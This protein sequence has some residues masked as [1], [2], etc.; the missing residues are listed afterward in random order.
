[1]FYVN[2]CTQQNLRAPLNGTKNGIKHNRAHRYGKIISDVVDYTSL[3]LIISLHH[4]A[5]LLTLYQQNGNNCSLIKEH[6]VRF[7]LI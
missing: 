1:M 4:Q 7:S 6:M 2:Q 5:P 3:N